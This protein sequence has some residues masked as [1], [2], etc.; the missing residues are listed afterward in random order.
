M[1]LY[2]T[3]T[4]GSDALASPRPRHALTLDTNCLISLARQEP[5]AASIET[6]ILRHRAGLLTLRVVAASASERGPGGVSLE[7]YEDFERFVR[8]LGLDDLPVLLPLGIFG[9]TYW[10]HALWGDDEGRMASL[11]DQIWTI[12]FA[13]TPRTLSAGSPDR[14][15]LCDA[16]M[17]WAHIY[18]TGHVFI[19]SDRHFHAATK[20]ARLISLGAGQ[21]YTPAQAVNAQRSSSDHLPN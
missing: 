11:L 3:A 2:D 8:L 19:S 21:I 4:D 17:M 12:L 13:S 1:P 5:A 16:L 10:D 7:T 18:H 14:N 15:R 9:V 6:L 20:K